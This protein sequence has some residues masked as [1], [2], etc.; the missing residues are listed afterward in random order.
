MK[1]YDF[2]LSYHPSK[3]NV[4]ANALS[5]RSNAASLCAI[6]EWRLIDA[7]TDV[8]IMVF[9][10]AEQATVASLFM[11]PKL[12]RQIIVAQRSDPRLSMIL[13]MQD[14][15]MDDSSVVRLRGRLYVPSSVKAEL[16]AEGHWSL[17]AIHLDST[18]MYRN[19]RRHFW[20]PRMKK[21]VATFIS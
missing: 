10:D 19:L 8:V 7:V 17:F 2:E 20:W 16:L 6:K 12:Y 5:R 3:E 9:R 18:K 21:H 15:Y 11:M 14:V 4:I 1:D 13:Q